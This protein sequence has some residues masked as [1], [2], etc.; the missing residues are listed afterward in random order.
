VAALAL[1]S[2]VG[3]LET[4]RALKRLVHAGA[5]SLAWTATLV[6]VE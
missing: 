4:L 1:T 5:V 6:E 3:E 2:G